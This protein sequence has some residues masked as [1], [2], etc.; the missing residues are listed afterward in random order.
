MIPPKSTASSIRRKR[1]WKFSAHLDPDAPLIVAGSG[2]AIQPSRP[3]RAFHA[4]RP[5]SDRGQLER[6]LAGPGRHAESQRL[7]DQGRRAL[8]HALERGFHRRASS[9]TGLRRWLDERHASTHDQSHVRDLAD[10]QAARARTRNS[11]ARLAAN[12]SSDKAIMGVFDEGC[13]GMFNAIIPDELLHPTGVFKERLSQ[14]ALYAA[15][16][17]GQRR[18]SPRGA[19]IGC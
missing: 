16:R 11:G 18:R 4:S 12:S 13:M 9:E 7:A 15:M 10:G 17:H 3:A 6:H 2:L 8:H 1:A 14:S 5:D 19:A